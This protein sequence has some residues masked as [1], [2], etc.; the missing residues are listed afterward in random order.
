[1]DVDGVQRRAIRLIYFPTLWE[2]P[3]VL[4]PNFVGFVYGKGSDEIQRI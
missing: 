2:I 4:Y 3:K 1:V